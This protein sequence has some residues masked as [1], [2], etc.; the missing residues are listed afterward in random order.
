MT[1]IRYAAQAD[2][3]RTPVPDYLHTQLL[4]QF[5]KYLIVGGMPAAV[6][7]FVSSGNL[8]QVR[9][10]QQQLIDLNRWDI[11]KYSP[12]EALLIKDIYDLIPS[13]LNQQNKRFILKKLNQHARMNRYRE[14]FV[15]LA[16]AGVALPTFNVE[17]P[18]YPL[19]LS[20]SSNLFKLFL[21]DVGLLTSTFIKDISARI[22]TKNPDINYGVIYE[23]AVAQE[24]AAQGFDLYY[25]RNKK[26]G[27]LDFLIETHDGRTL[28]IEVKSGKAYKRHSALRNLLSVP[29]YHFDEALVLSEAN[30]ETDG[31]ITYLPIYLTYLL[32]LL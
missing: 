17:E 13:E 15:W 21:A 8:Q 31:P 2:L 32:S 3:S 22:L 11:S 18:K 16:D 20:R 19:K 4:E 5:H 29:Q 10:T 26:R 1:V 24:L 25:Y 23:N 7:E 6:S 28:P 9:R 27:E 30:L 14:S 12:S